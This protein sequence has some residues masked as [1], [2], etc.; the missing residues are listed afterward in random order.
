M[1]RRPHRH[2]FLGTDSGIGEGVQY[3][4]EG[5]GKIMEEDPEYLSERASCLLGGS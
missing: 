4:L 1:L 3:A 2:P 5:I